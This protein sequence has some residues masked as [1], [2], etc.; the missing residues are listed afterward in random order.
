MTARG[1]LLLAAGLG[2]AGCNPLDPFATGF[3]AREPAVLYQARHKNTPPPLADE[4]VV[5][6][7]NIRYAGG[8]LRFFWE[9]NGERGWMTEGEVRDH[10]RALAEKINQVNPDV[11]LLQEVDVDS[12]RCA[13]IDNLQWLLDH[14]A[15]D[16]G[17]YASQWKADYVPSDGVGRI[18]S[19]NAI[20]SRWPLA[21]AERLALPLIGSQD[22]LTNYFYLKRNIL[23]AT[24]E[25]AAGRLW[26]VNTHTEAF[27]ED[28][29]KREHLTTFAQV[30]DALD[31]AGERFVAGGDLNAV[32]PDATRRADF[33]DDACGDARFEGDDYTGQETW[34]DPLF[35]RYAPAVTPAEYRADEAGHFTFTGDEQLGWQRT[36]DYLFTNR[37][38]VPGDTVTH[39]SAARGGLETLSRSDHAPVSALLEV[40]P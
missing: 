39:Q 31:D 11:L 30:L 36:L 20:L 27:A 1:L 18:D 10:L 22:A 38:F 3:A 6:T 40:R 32:P 14:T 9:C 33:P 19:G 21:N 13:Y 16:Y 7:W 17:A 26:L 15:L 37:R 29:T 4:L 12:K 23:R 5:M 24:I 35:A 34:L 28:E 25:S 2:A 8:R